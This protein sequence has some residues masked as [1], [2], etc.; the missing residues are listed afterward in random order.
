MT[1]RLSQPTLYIPSDLK[2]NKT[3][4]T[5][6]TKLI[7][8]AFYRSKESDPVKWSNDT[9]RFPTEDALHV[10]LGDEGSVMAV[11]FDNSQKAPVTNGNG[12]GNESNGDV[13]ACAAAVPWKGGWMKE[14]A[15]TES[16]WELKTV[17]VDGDPKYHHRGLAVKVMRFLEEYLVANTRRQLQRVGKEGK[18][19]LTLWI[20]A[21][22]CINGIYW[23]KKGYQEVRRKNEG[24]GVWSCMT[25]FEMVVLKKEVTFDVNS[26]SWTGDVVNRVSS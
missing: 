7:N 15:N 14:G 18:G 8:N 21:A 20:L 25:S 2:A 3:L 24:M 11:I 5:S 23:R 26:R 13:V 19:T 4:S 1:T 17:C 12:N 16:G 22:E 10:M 6:V 9:F